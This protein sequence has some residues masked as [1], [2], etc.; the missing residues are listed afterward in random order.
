MN[1]IARSRRPRRQFIVLGAILATLVAAVTGCAGFGNFALGDKTVINVATVSNP[2]MERMQA[3]VPDFEKQ[4]PNI[5]VRF[6]TLPENTLR[7][8]LTQNIA[9]G[10]GAYDLATVGV[11]E[12][13]IW[14]K[15]GWLA[16]VQNRAETTPGYDVNDILP[17]VRD[18]LS[19]N[20]SLYAVP[21]YAES[22]FMMYRKDLFAKA[23]LTMPDHPT[24]QQ[25][26]EFARKLNDP[27]HGVAGICLRGEAGWGS[28][29]GPLGVI[30]HSF[31]GSF[32]TSDYHSNVTGT[33]FRDATKFYV[34]LLRNYGQ[35]GATSSAFPECLNTFSQG[36]AAMWFDATVAAS[37]VTDPAHSKVAD[38]VGFAAA[39]KAV[40]DTGGWLWAWSLA[41]I[42][43]SHKKDAA[44]QFMSWATSKQYINLVAQKYGA[45]LVPPGT[46]AS[47]YQLPEYQK[48]AHAYADLT[49]ESIKNAGGQI[50]GAPSTERSF[51][52]AI[53][54]WQD[55]GT[56]MSQYVT[57]AIAGNISVDDALRQAAAVGNDTAVTGGYRR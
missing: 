25:I 24:W 22:S 57:S 32:Y 20:G 51:Y 54:Q 29:F 34:D 13:P 7:D 56:A 1:K 43:T 33:G 6:T 14:A 44:W 23:G 53:P 28:V 16:N 50:P 12:V 19:Y 48:A 4:H 21:F 46:R 30:A 5:K 9:T 11:Y 27:A 55:A 49:L 10:S 35:P 15:N 52:V 41:M 47:T 3:L 8:K 37:T 39:P 40:R 31:G 36:N 42:N 38:N 26:G 2:D 45:N 17:S 18:T